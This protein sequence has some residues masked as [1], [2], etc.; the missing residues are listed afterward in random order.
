V[1]YTKAAISYT[2]GIGR[3]VNIAIPGGCDQRHEYDASTT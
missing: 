2:T 1:S 3:F